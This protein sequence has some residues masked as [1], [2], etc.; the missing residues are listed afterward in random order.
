MRMWIEYFKGPALTPLQTPA[1]L[2]S[3]HAKGPVSMVLWSRRGPEDNLILNPTLAL[4]LMQTPGPNRHGRD[5][6]GAPDSRAHFP[7]RGLE[8]AERGVA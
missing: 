7:R 1:D 6:C 3:L 8:P 5:P 2:A 4:T